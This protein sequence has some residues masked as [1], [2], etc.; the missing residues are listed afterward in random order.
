MFD[1]ELR[2]ALEAQSRRVQGEMAPLLG[3]ILM[4]EGILTGSDLNVELEKQ[5]RERVRLYGKEA[6]GH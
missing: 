4:E 2:K 1:E 3:S 6:T 5:A